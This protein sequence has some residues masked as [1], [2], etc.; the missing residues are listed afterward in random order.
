MTYDDS[1]RRLAQTLAAARDAALT[2]A[3]AAGSQEAGNI[4]DAALAAHLAA[5]DP[6]AQYLTQTEGDARYASLPVA[7]ASLSG[8]P[9]TFAPATHTHA[10]AAITS[11]VVAPERLG[12]G[13]P[14][15]TVYLRGD[16]AWATVPGGNATSLQGRAVASDAP[17]AGQALVWDDTAGQWEPGTVSGGPGGGGDATSIQ[18]RPVT[19][20]VPADGQI[21][22]WDDTAGQWGLV[23]FPEGSLIQ[24]R[25]LAYPSVNQSISNGVP[26]KVNFGTEVYDE[27]GFYS[28]VSSTWTPPAGPVWIGAHV[29]FDNAWGD[30]N[31]Y[32]LRLHKNGS[33]FRQLSVNAKEVM[34][35]VV[36]DYASGT[37]VYEIQVT[38]YA[39]TRIVRATGQA[40]ASFFGWNAASLSGIAGSGYANIPGLKASPDRLGSFGTMVKEFEVGDSLPT[41]TPST[42]AVTDIGVTLPSHFYA[43][44]TDSTERFAYFPWTPAGDFDVRAKLSVG[45]PTG[46][47]GYGAGLTI[48]SANNLDR[49][50]ILVYYDATTGSPTVQG[51]TYTSGAG[52]Q[53][54]SL[55]EGAEESYLRITRSGSSVALWFSVTGKT[56]TQIW[57]GTFSFTP[58]QIGFR[59]PPSP[60]E[61]CCD[62]LRTG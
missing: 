53:R 62:W 58:A 27:G 25:F 48:A 24:A 30:T 19:D 28:P 59:L 51:L 49:V 6:H 34:S 12:S 52:T 16:G 41:W 60:C 56:W 7:W 14:D 9:A 20:E 17:S 18:G 45:M 15:A 37:D 32:V 35:A 21:L 38:Q 5:P 44:A 40:T 26:T 2:S 11:G 8:V 46:A 55:W 10:A 31:I 50:V 3:A 39:G 42:P 36:P 22:A 33:L 29:N 23:T 13:T 1:I 43:K 47:T 57:S 4:A 54:G 61:V